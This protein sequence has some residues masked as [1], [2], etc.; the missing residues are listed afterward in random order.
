MC[1]TPSGVQSSTLLLPPDQVRG[2]G[3]CGRA[4]ALAARASAGRSTEPGTGQSFSAAPRAASRVSN[5]KKPRPITS[6]T[7]VS[8]HS[9]AMTVPIWAVI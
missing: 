4:V 8:T 7:I 5:R 1:C 3:V 2:P 9:P 6:S